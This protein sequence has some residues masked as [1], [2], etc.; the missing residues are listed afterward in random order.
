MGE[1]IS[2]PVFDSSGNP[3]TD[4]TPV[5]LAYKTK[6]GGALSAPAISHLGGGIYGFSPTN[7]DVDAG[8]AYLISTGA[9]PKYQAGSVFLDTAPFAVVNL[10]DSAEALWTGAAPSVGIYKDF[11][12]ANRMAPA[13]NTLLGAHFFSLV[14]SIGDIATGTAFRIDAPVGALPAYL[15]G[16]FYLPTGTPV[17]PPVF[18]GLEAFEN[19]VQAQVVA[20]T[21]FSGSKV[22]WANQTRDRPTR[23]FVELAFLKEETTNFTEQY[24]ADT[25]GSPEGEEL[26]LYSKEHVEPTI[27]VRVFSNDVVGNNTA[28][29]IAKKIRAYLGRDSVQ[30]ALGAVAVVNRGTV[31]DISLVLETEHEGRAILD[32]KF[33]LSQIEEETVTYIQTVTVETNVTSTDETTTVLSFTQP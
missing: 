22:I 23:P 21:G 20:A 7:A 5:F 1:R 10:T 28:R 8:A 27:Q 13:L 3:K 4:A 9:F 31:R 12:G 25:V 24:Q 18:T 2:F 14:P 19:A 15:A 11:A 6:T 17:S 29:N 30:Y 32:L 16:S 33:R 26:T